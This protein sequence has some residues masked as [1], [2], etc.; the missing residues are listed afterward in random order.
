[1]KTGLKRF[2]DFLL[3]GNVYVALG[4]ACL[5][6]STIIQLNL[7]HSD[8]V[9]PI[10]I[11]FSTLFIYNFQRVFYKPQANIAL[12]SVRRTWIF[13]HPFLIKILAGIGFTGVCACL[14]FVGV[15]IFFY[16]SP[17]LFLCIAYFIPF[18]K[19]RKNPFLKLLTLVSVWTMVTAVV[20]ILL[21]HQSLMDVKNILHICIRFCF[22]LAIC[23]PFD[24]RDLKIDEAD[25]I[26]TIPHLFGENKTRWL[27]IAFMFLYDG[28]IIL[29]YRIHFLSFAVFVALFVSAILNTMLVALS[30]SK[31]SEYFYVAGID[32]TMILQGV[33]LIAVCFAT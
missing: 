12:H 14:L 15:R 4:A 19:L 13:T 26:S 5:V 1:V 18:I 31:R 9:Y 32:G 25:A 20:P 10:L 30:T 7:N 21:A 28:L 3:F 16:L 27:A 6:Q 11:F 2:W 33:L 29:S 24:I 17:L 23:I 8:F 22:M